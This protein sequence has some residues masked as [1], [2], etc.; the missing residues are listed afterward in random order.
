M[1]EIAPEEA[2]KLEVICG[3]CD[4]LIRIRNLAEHF[5]SEHSEVFLSEN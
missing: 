3:F 5:K 1:R 2:E 4:K